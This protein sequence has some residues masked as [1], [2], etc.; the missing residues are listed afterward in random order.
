MILITAAR[1]LGNLFRCL[2]HRG[3]T[4]RTFS[5]RLHRHYSWAQ[6]RLHID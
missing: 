4:R 3:E 6:D 5:L 1:K 2:S